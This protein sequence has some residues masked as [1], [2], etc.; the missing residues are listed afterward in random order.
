MGVDLQGGAAALEGKTVVFEMKTE[1][2]S[3]Q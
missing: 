2:K 1:K 3:F